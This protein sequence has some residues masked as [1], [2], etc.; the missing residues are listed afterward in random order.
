MVIIVARSVGVAVEAKEAGAMTN[1]VALAL[2][3]GTNL[4]VLALTLKDQGAGA[5]INLVVLAILL[6]T[7]RAGAT[8]ILV[9]LA[10]L[11]R[12]GGAGATT[13]LV[14]LALLLRTRRAGVATDLVVLDI[15]LNLLLQR[16]Q[17]KSK[18]LCFLLDHSHFFSWRIW[19]NHF[20]MGGKKLQLYTTIASH[21]NIGLLI[22]I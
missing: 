4:I 12:I 3:D 18:I 2:K 21:W 7:R 11:L 19:D 8:A 16:L 17:Q 13:N 15:L 10:L 9:V 1:R 22:L 6:R 20:Q 14:V 5:A